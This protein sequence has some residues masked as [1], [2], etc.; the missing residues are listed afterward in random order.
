MGAEEHARTS[1][2]LLSQNSETEVMEAERRKKRSP[3]QI[4]YSSNCEEQGSK[5]K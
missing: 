1:L 2:D 5:A 4:D 3:S